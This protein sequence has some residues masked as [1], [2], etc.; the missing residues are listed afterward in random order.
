MDFIGLTET[1]T[2]KDITIPGYTLIGTAAPDDIKGGVLVFV[3]VPHLWSFIESF[4]N[5]G[6]VVKHNPSSSVITTIYGS[7][8]KG[9]NVG[10]VDWIVKLTSHH[11]R[12]ITGG[13]FNKLQLDG[14]WSDGFIESGYGEAHTFERGQVRSRIDKVMTQHLKGH[15][16][17]IDIPSVDGT[18][19]SDHK[20]LLWF[21]D[22]KHDAFTRWKV[23]NWSLD[24]PKCLDSISQLTDK[25]L[26]RGWWIM[27]NK[28]RKDYPRIT[29]KAIGNDSEALHKLV[30]FKVDKEKFWDENKGVDPKTSAAIQRLSLLKSSVEKPSE[31]LIE[32]FFKKLYA[33][34][35][36]PIAAVACNPP[37]HIS[38]DDVKRYIS[39][40]SKG[41]APGPSGL[42]FEFLQRM[43]DKIAPTLAHIFNQALCGITIDERWKKGVITLLPKSGDLTKIENWRPI[44]LLNTEW[45]IYTSI[46]RNKLEEKWQNIVGRNQIGFRKGRWIQEHHL[47]LQALLQ[48]Y[49]D[50][51]GAVLFLD[52]KHAYDSLKHQY[53]LDRM[54]NI[55]GHNWT[56]VI[57]GI[58]GGESSL[59]IGQRWVGHCRIN[60][61]VRQGDSISPILFNIALAP[62][63]E[64]LEESLEGAS[65]GD[66]KIKYLAFADDIA[67]F[68]K[69]EFDLVKLQSLLQDWEIT[70]GMVVNN[71]KTKMFAWH[72]NILKTSPWENVKFFRF[73]GIPIMN[74]GNIHWE[75]VSVK[76]SARLQLVAKVAARMSSLRSR[77][78]CVNG[79]AISVIYHVLRADG[80]ID[81][82][83]ADNWRKDIKLAL[84]NK[85]T[86]VAWD[87]LTTPVTNGGFGLFDPLKLQ[88]HIRRRWVLY[89]WR[90]EGEE[91]L[92][93][94]LFNFWSQCSRT[95]AKRYVGSLLAWNSLEAYVPFWLSIAG[96]FH[97]I[98]KGRNSLFS[99]ITHEWMWSDEKG[100]RMKVAKYFDKDGEKLVQLTDGSVWNACCPLE[101]DNDLNRLRRMDWMVWK[102][103]ILHKTKSGKWKLESKYRETPAQKRWLKDHN[104]NW[105]NEWT[106]ARTIHKLPRNL[107]H[108]WLDALNINLAIRY[109]IDPCGVCH[110]V[111][112]SDHFLITCNGIKKLQKRLQA[113]E[114]NLGHKIIVRW[115]NWQLHVVAMHGGDGEQTIGKAKKF[116]KRIV[117]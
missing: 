38:V 14:E 33:S 113:K 39:K 11:P 96:S 105:L 100:R 63:L 41:K 76:F 44:T 70:S 56:Q 12:A 50:T 81:T 115:C 108:W 1:H 15:V 26:K 83:I 78:L 71:Q 99:G 91:R 19:L 46:V 94:D 53:I 20:P 109:K 106:Q 110:E 67:I 80:W 88:K 31:E 64:K 6:V 87:R 57:A 112:G 17:H 111:V 93:D 35:R 45:K 40:G 28:L 69:D 22:K 65:L 85:G 25:Y 95:I 61:G 52:F 32:A 98:S 74:D 27:I 9:G 13:D 60:A 104:F 97:K 4:E 73:L 90:R 103:Q 51:F 2:T 55:G 7:S 107:L 48:A 82:S 101:E 10:I 68:L 34:D 102:E 49:K 117:N 116:L 36:T 29:A 5:R 3:K 43:C 30:A 58:L 54:K 77:V 24:I 84:G 89:L 23:P 66:F 86:R 62:L 114:S 18:L 72:D 79:Y 21:N 42:T 8:S 16:I 47:V 75:E 37:F 92:I 59:W